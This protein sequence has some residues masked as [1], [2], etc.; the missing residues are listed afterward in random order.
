MT[1]TI[2]FEVVTVDRTSNYKTET[3]LSKEEM[4]TE[5]TRYLKVLNSQATGA[6]VGNEVISPKFDL[7]TIKETK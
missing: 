1:Y 6:L 5:V 4:L 7:T 3:T 2:E